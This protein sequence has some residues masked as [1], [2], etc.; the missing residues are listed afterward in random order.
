MLDE[1]AVIAYRCGRYRESLNA[2]R[3]LFAL[4]ALPDSERPRIEANAKFAERGLDG[5]G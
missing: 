3:K 5:E 2:C 4:D 1:F